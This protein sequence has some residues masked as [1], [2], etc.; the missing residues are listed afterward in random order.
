MNLT[1]FFFTVTLAVG[2]FWSLGF[3]LHATLDGKSLAHA[4]PRSCDFHYLASQIAR[5]FNVVDLTRSQQAWETGVTKAMPYAKR[6]Y[7]SADP[8]YILLHGWYEL[9]ED[10]LRGTR[11]QVIEA[12]KQAHEQKQRQGMR[13]EISFLPGDPLT[14]YTK[15]QF[16]LKGILFDDLHVTIIA[17]PTCFLGLEIGGPSS[18]FNESDWQFIN[19]RLSAV[20]KKVLEDFGPITFTK[21]QT[22]LDHGSKEKRRVAA[23]SVRALVS[24]MIGLSGLIGVIYLG[25]M[26]NNR[27]AAR[28]LQVGGAMVAIILMSVIAGDREMA[29]KAG[30]YFVYLA[31]AFFVIWEIFKKLSLRRQDSTS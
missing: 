7:T 6:I 30:V 26:S 25:R 28:S 16:K 31:I 10:L 8:D 18:G 12:I 17:S 3:T 14:S 4:E 1:R 22:L 2:A 21:A 15:R 11:D 24:A 23:R 9:P 20:R 29:I 13:A 5:E 27:V 19:D